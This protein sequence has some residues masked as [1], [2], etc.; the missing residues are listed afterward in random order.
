M[1]K[2]KT[3][4]FDFVL[5]QL[6]SVAPVVKP[7]F[8]CHA[9]YVKEK[10]VLMLRNKEDF[11]DDNGVWIATTTE[12]HESL[13]RNFPSMRSIGMFEGKITGWQNLP[14]EAGDFEESV[15]EA[16]DLI[17]KKDIRIGK[18]PKPRKKKKKL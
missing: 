17:L 5:E 11:P 13:R 14:Y 12:H 3:I 2:I 4:P 15:I 1:K 7:M 6:Y 18:V 10:I 9:V 16:C 8:G